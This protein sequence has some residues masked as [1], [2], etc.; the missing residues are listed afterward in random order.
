MVLDPLGLWKRVCSGQRSLERLPDLPGNSCSWE[1][2]PWSELW[3]GGLSTLRG[4]PRALEGEED[5]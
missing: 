1:D 5:K 2:E 4:H 3:E